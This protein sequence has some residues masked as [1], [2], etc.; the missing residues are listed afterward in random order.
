M[1]GHSKRR[2]SERESHGDRQKRKRKDAARKHHRPTKPGVSS[3][4]KRSR[5]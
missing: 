3:Y 5:T 1:P 4:R 2:G